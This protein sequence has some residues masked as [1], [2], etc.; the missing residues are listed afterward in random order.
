MMC[1]LGSR[2]CVGQPR[3]ARGEECARR[4]RGRAMRAAVECECRV[5][6]DDDE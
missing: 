5:C 4:R 1:A 2:V 3:G 6:S